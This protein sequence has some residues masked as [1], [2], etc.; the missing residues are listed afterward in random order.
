MIT[1]WLVLLS[2]APVL[3]QT[4]PNDLN[5]RGLAASERHDYEAAEK[6]FQSAIALWR[7]RGP[8]YDL[9]VAFVQN[10]LGQLY[11]DM[12]DRQRCRAMFDAALPA[13]RRILGVKDLRTLTV[14]NLLGGVYM[15]L[16][17]HPKAAA[18]FQEALAIERQFYPNDTELAR[19]LSGL[20]SLAMQEDRAAEGVPLA[21]EALEIAV[22]ATGDDS[23]DSALA[24]ANLAEAHRVLGR[25]DRAI[26]LFRKSRAIYEKRLGPDHPRV[27]SVLTQEGII[28]L[29]E[30]KLGTAEQ[31]FTRA[32]DIV[33]KSC[34]NCSYERIVAENDLALLRIKQGK[35]SEADALLTDVL[36]QQERAGGLPHPE[37]AVTLNSLAV[38]REKERRYED[39]ERLKR[40]AAVMAATYR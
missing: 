34:P 24:Y 36:S 5:V 27:S 25:P 6:L 12:A 2:F 11:C 9:H 26:P 4:D 30:G 21:E 33:R 3:A 20:A 10:N 15:M 40:R 35:Y 13:Y 1:V 32:L 38:V 39:A 22:K 37:I 29:N 31:A 18:L 17:D 8:A 14:M 7:A 16:G 28:A 23:L 19:S